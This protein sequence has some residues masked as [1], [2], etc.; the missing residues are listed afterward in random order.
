MLHK[1][2]TF[3]TGNPHK[4]EEVNSLI[5][6]KFEITGLKDLGF[7]EEIPETSDSIQGN[8]IQK[9]KFIFDRFE[10]NCFAEDTGLEVD[11]L[12]GQPG[13]HTARYAGPARDANENMDL[14]LKNLA[15]APNRE[16]QFRTVV[17]LYL[18]GELH[19]FEGIVRGKI[20]MKKTGSAGFGYDPIFIPNDYQQTFAELSS[21]IKNKISHRGKAVQKLISFLSKIYN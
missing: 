16:A 12:G 15:D 18:E 21:E 20:S 10:I 3:V 5:K 1:K 4:V 13:I 8:A 6:D 17:A 2:L 19:C 11:F 7:S 9:A 14:L